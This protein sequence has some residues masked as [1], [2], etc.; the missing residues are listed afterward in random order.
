[1]M[2]LFCGFA[3]P[4]FPTFLIFKNNSWKS[5]AKFN[6]ETELLYIR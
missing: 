1:M 4:Y 2:T 5:S 6:F 3:P